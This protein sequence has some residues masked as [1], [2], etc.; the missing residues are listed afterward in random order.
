MK[1]R[2]KILPWHGWI[3][4]LILL[5][6]GSFSA[7]DYIMSIIEGENY[8]RSSGMTEAQVEYFMNLPVWAIIAWTLSVWGILLAAVSLLFRYKISIL[9]FSLSLIGTLLY[10]LYV[11]GLSDGQ[12][13]MGAIWPAPIII[14]AISAAMIYYSKRL[15]SYVKS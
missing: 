1:N 9:F 13:A 6:Y 11:F 2:R 5:L 10:I 12:E 3:L 4:G 14:A 8:Y 7:Y 15:L